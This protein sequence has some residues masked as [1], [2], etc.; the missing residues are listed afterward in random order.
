ME[1]SGR[2]GREW[3]GR[4]WKGYHAASQLFSRI[5][6]ISK[7]SKFDLVC[8]FIQLTLNQDPAA[9]DLPAAPYIRLPPQQVHYMRAACCIHHGRRKAPTASR[10]QMQ[11][12]ALYWIPHLH[13]PHSATLLN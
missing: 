2:E 5:E 6:F 4:E 10:L 8:L 1:Q 7:F 3:Q 13:P 12:T 9:L 11:N